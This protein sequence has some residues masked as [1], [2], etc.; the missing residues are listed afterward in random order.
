MP[1]NLHLTSNEAFSLY[2]KTGKIPA[3][4]KPACM[5]DRTEVFYHEYED[6]VPAPKMMVTS[7]LWV[8]LEVT[9]AEV[10]NGANV[11]KSMQSLSEMIMSQINGTEYEEEYIEEPVEEEET[12]EYLDEEAER[13]AARQEEE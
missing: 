9:F 8:Q 3:L 6:S 11:S 10:W 2:E 4:T 1:L 7:N 13:E 12:V 5:D